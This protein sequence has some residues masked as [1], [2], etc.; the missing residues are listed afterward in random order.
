MPSVPSV[1]KNIL[2]SLILLFAAAMTLPAQQRKV[3]GMEVFHSQVSEEALQS[4]VVFL[5]G[6]ECGGR[7]AG[8]EGS[9]KAAEWVAERFRS[10]GL[11]EP[12]GGYFRE[13]ATPSGVHGRNI[14]GFL[15]CAGAVRRGYIL[16]FTHYDGLGTLDGKFYPGA[17][18][19]CSGTAALLGAAKMISAAAKIGKRYGRDVIFACTDG[20]Y[21]GMAGTETLVDDIKGG[22]IMDPRRGAAVAPGSISVAADIDQIGC[23]LSPISENN[24]DYMIALTSSAYHRTL[25]SSSNEKYGLALELG[26]DYYGSDSFTDMFYRHASETA[27][28]LGAGIPSV[29]FTSGITMNNNKERDTA[30]TIAPA[31]LRKRVCLIFHWID[32]VL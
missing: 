10:I 13:F 9:L 27:V 16:V 17:D 19:D 11:D 4:D 20:K 22:R 23:T 8:T 31:V 28:F 32:R 12:E 30:D 6:K 25:L 15:H 21:K 1:T 26:F 3:A 18:S 2:L 24:P 7:S 29:L 14:V 5:S